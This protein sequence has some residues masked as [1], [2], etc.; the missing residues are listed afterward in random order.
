MRRDPATGEMIRLL[1]RRWS[2]PDHPAAE[3]KQAKATLREMMHLPA[4]APTARW[5]AAAASRGAEH[6]LHTIERRGLA[7]PHP[8]R[9]LALA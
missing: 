6:T 2:R 1:V 4:P 5:A 9:P 3:L 7:R 8:N